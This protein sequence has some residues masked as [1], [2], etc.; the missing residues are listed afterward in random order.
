V[1]DHQREVGEDG[2]FYR[3][4]TYRKI[5][6]QTVKEAESRRAS[7]YSQRRL[8]PFWKER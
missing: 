5:Q 7:G 1:D 8:Y 3:A 4:G 2:C 6:V